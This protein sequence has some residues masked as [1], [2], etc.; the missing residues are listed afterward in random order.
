MAKVKSSSLSAKGMPMPKNGLNPTV[1]HK[2][3]PSKGPAGSKSSMIK[4][5]GN[6][7][8]VK[9]PPSGKPA[10]NRLP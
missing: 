7:P 9:T 1:L 6:T 4:G 5:M 3:G 10:K 2:G 8:V